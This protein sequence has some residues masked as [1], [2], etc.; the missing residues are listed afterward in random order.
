MTYSISRLEVFVYRAPIEIPIMTSFGTMHDRPAVT[1][2]IEDADGCFGWGEVWCNYPTCGAEHRARLVETVFAPL[3]LNYEFEQPEEIFDYLTSKTHVLAIQ[4]A[5][6][7]P[8]AQSI[9]GLDIAIWDLVARK[10]GE[11]LYQRLGGTA[12][13]IPVYASGINPT[14]AADTIGRARD[15]GYRAFKVKIGFGHDAD[16]AT[17]EGA[18]A[19]LSDNERLMADANQAWTVKEALAFLRDAGA[20]PLGW[21][22]EPIRA[23]RPDEE[24]QLLASATKIP[25]AAGENI[26]GDADYHRKIQ[27]RSLGV[28]QPDICKWGG[29]TANLP[30]VRSI[31]EA[32]IRYCP[33]Y[34]GG[35][36]GLIASAHLLAAVG[37]DGALEVDFNDN[38]L[39]EGLAQPFPK[40]AEGQIALGPEPGLGT[41]PDV[42]AITE[43][44]VHRAEVR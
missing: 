1:V 26:R 33:H 21:L 4:T 20:M 17:L 32:G 13:S 25:I 31:L 9:A 7:G 11:P 41:A 6:I 15:Q 8:I 29:F 14:D 22:E 36:I 3:L 42:A 10:E 38:P 37:G 16:L 19:D 30:V 39:R 43:F 23:D 27:G 28:L 44:R 35:G 12:R 2:R 24:W 5:E 34:L 18:F 40:M